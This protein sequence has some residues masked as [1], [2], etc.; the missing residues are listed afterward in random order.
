MNPHVLRIW[1]APGLEPAHRMVLLTIARHVP[2]GAT[3]ALVNRT[4]LAQRLCTSLSVVGRA[5]SHGQRLDLCWA[6]KNGRIA[7]VADSLPLSERPAPKP[8]V[9]A[10]PTTPGTMAVTA[11]L[12]MDEFD[13]Q[14]RQRH[15]GQR[16]PFAYGKDNKL[17]AGAAKALGSRAQIISAVRLYLLR[18][19]PFYRNAAYSFPVFASV[20][21][22]KFVAG[23]AEHPDDENEWDRIERREQSEARR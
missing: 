16:Y 18:T 20:F 10:A 9:T 5:I 13:S 12:V 1:D 3:E 17:A 8:A 19:E 21:L 23:V 15:K 11:Q 4:A 14:W 6:L 7:F 2:D 22:P